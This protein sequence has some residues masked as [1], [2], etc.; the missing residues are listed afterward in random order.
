MVGSVVF[1][2]IA[3]LPLTLAET[4]AVFRTG[5]FWGQDGGRYFGKAYQAAVQEETV[6]CK[7][8]N[9][10]ELATMNSRFGKDYVPGGGISVW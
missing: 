5:R 6:F 4:L 2:Y 1:E 10:L 7:G 3:P 8:N 9:N